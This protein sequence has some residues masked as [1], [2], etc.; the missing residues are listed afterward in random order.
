MANI[1]IKQG[2]EIAVPDFVITTDEARK[3]DL[4]DIIQ[5]GTTSS[6]AISSGTYFYLNNVLVRAKVDIANGA[7]F[8]LNTNYEVVTAGALNELN[9]K[10]NYSTTEH[11]VG[12]WV[13]GKT[14]YEKTVDCGTLPNTTSKSVA[15]NISNIDK[16]VYLGGIAYAG[17]NSYPLPFVQVSAGNVQGIRINASSTNVVIVSSY[18]VSSLTNSYV[19][20]R[21]TKSS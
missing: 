5:T 15:H 21:Y 16:I 11:V 14:L 18:D 12:K 2:L 8:T 9:E 17:T 13:D 10:F 6:Q 4:T 20:L 1:L 7:T 3:V 19:T